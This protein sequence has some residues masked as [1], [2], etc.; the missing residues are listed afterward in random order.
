MK[1]FINSINNTNHEPGYSILIKR[2]N[3][4]SLDVNQWNPLHKTDKLNNSKKSHTT[5]IRTWNVRI[6]KLEKVK[7]MI[8]KKFWDFK[9]MQN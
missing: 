2:R 6:R 8:K 9:Y 5:N 3:E 1:Y 4:V 7:T